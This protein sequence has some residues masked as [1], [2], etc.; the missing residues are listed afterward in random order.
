MFER[1]T[2]DYFNMSGR[3]PRPTKKYN[4][5]HYSILSW[6]FQNQCS[7][8]RSW[9]MCL[10]GHYIV[11]GRMRRWCSLRSHLTQQNQHKITLSGNEWDIDLSLIGGFTNVTNKYNAFHF[12][13]SLGLFKIN[14]RHVIIFTPFYISNA[15]FYIVLNHIKIIYNYFLFFVFYFLEHISLVF[16]KH[17]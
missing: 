15:D 17:P 4:A 11:C 16:R 10:L 14:V 6:S 1:L 3:R 2:R 5:F 13:S 8:G 12:L 9:W 7:R